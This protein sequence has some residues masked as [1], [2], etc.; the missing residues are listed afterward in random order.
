MDD[1][2]AWL[3]PATTLRSEGAPWIFIYNPY[4]PRFEKR[5]SEGDYFKA[6]EDEAPAEEGSQVKLIVQGGMERL[7]LV[8]SLQ[9]NLER[10]G[11]SHMAIQREMDRERKRA[12]LDILN[13]AHAAKVRTG[14]WLLFCSPSEVNE[15]WELVAKATANNKLGIAAKVAPRSP[16][17]DQ[18]RDR[19][20]CVYIPDFLDRSDVGRVL[21]KLREL[22]LVES[23]GRPVY[24]KPDAFTYN[25][26]SHG[27]P[28]GLS[29]SIYSSKET[30]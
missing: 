24:Y 14:K 29:A 18:R 30:F 10:A 20:L 22:R 28:W 3:P 11:K 9:R 16:F 5:H 12:A 6:N 27:N 2:L 19:L 15:I 1:F 23:R 17:D 4:I 13:L 25:G 21:Q 26:I 8:S 7:E